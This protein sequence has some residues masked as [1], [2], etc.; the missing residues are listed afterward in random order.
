[1]VDT[2]MATPSVT[3]MGTS[4]LGVEPRCKEC[5]AGASLSFNWRYANERRSPEDLRSLGLFVHWREL[6]RGQLYRCS[7]CDEVWHLDEDAERMTHVQSERLPLLLAWSAETIALPAAISA[8]IQRIGPTPPD[9][10]GN[11]R[12]RRVT[13]CKVITR[14]GEQFDQ[15][16]ICVQRDAPVQDYL[17][18][19]LGSEVA[20][21]NASPFAL[22][23]VVRE[24]SSRAQEV[25]M[26][27]SPTLIEMPDGRRFVMNGMTS[28]MAEHG[29]NASEARIVSGDYFSERPTP[30][31]VTPSSEIPYFIVDGDP[32][33]TAA[34]WTAAEATS[35][36]KG[37]LRTLLGKQ[38]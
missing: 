11:G 12:E 23:R 15:A 19:R 36:A 8:V 3:L 10:Y 1:M 22:P 5:G 7:I 24:A 28:F 30:S 21:V 6:R 17:R 2:C 16:I 13:P 9:L 18:F 27:F 35:P 31:F 33:W 26:G 37:W 14:S 4:R 34:P 20:E 32:G 25:R 38:P 29:Y